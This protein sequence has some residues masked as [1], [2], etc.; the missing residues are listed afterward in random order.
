MTRQERRG[1]YA[2]GDLSDSSWTEEE[3]PQSADQPV[4]RREVRRKLASTAQDDE[5]LLEQELFQARDSVGQTS[6][7]TQRCFTLDSASELGFETHS[8]T[9]G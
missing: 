2:D 7:A 5:L 6:D 4:D 8:A 3:R 1:A 9:P